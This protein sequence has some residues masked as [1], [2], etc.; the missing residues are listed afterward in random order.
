LSH[1]SVIVQLPVTG[2]RYPLSPRVQTLKAILNKL[3]PKPG[4]QA[5][6]A[7]KALRVAPSRFGPKALR[8]RPTPLTEGSEPSGWAA[9]L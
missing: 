1:R 4:P 5:P 8:W 7:A 9:R 2:N 3:W 6:P